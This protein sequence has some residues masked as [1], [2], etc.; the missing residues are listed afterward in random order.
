MAIASDSQRH[1][2]TLQ[3]AGTPSSF[4]EVVL[5]IGDYVNELADIYRNDRLGVCA[6]SGIVK[7][8][9]GGVGF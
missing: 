5:N 4:F 7:A 1:L 8:G 9:W 3:Q 6:S 2:P